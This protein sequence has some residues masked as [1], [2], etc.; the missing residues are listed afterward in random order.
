[1]KQVDPVA[2]AR[3]LIRTRKAAG[4][5]QVELAK[6]AHKA[7]S[8]LSVLES[9]KVTRP[10]LGTILDLADALSV[11]PEDLIGEEAI[12]KDEAPRPEENGQR[13]AFPYPWMATAFS[14]LLSAWAKAV[15]QG[16][17][18]EHC[19][20]IASGALD[21]LDAVVPPLASM[22]NALPEEEQREREEL[23]RE[24][25]ELAREA[26]ETYEQGKGADRD[27]AEDS[28]TRQDEGIRE[29]IRRLTKE[30]A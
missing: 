30:I 6:K 10:H 27:V 16:Y 7:P 9:G 13:R 11:A 12:P 23:R 21:A 20:V 8:T 26:Y 2:L 24:L 22:W 25:V 18:P 14:D 29:E 17:S 4:L 3:N 15:E 1:M 19:R 28:H 5:T